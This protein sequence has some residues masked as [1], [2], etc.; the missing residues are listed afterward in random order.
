MVKANAVRICVV[1]DRVV[2]NPITAHEVPPEQVR[3]GASSAERRG[4]HP[5]GGGPAQKNRHGAV[6]PEAGTR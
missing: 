3:R 5:R 2:S 6:A 1:A 4:G